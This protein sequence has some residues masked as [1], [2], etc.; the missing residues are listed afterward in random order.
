M[1]PITAIMTSTPPAYRTTLRAFT[2]SEPPGD[3]A[4][5]R[6]SGARGTHRLEAAPQR[7][8]QLDPLDDRRGDGVAIHRAVDRDDERRLPAGLAAAVPGVVRKQRDL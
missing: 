8:R 3:P 6:P 4:L 1:A 5:R 2:R 7:D